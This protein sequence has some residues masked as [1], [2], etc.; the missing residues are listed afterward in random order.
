MI[1]TKCEVCGNKVGKLTIPLDDYP[2][3][4]TYLKRKSNTKFDQ[5]FVFCEN[6][7][8][9]QLENI[10]PQEDLYSHKYKFRTSKSSGAD[11]GSGFVYDYIIKNKL[12]E[13]YKTVIDIGCN[14]GY[15][16][17]RLEPYF[18]NLIGVDP[19]L[20]ENWKDNKI[21]LYADFIEHV[22]L[23]LEDCLVIT[24]QVLEHLEYPKMFIKKLLEKSNNNTRFIFAFPC[25]D[26]LV[27][28]YR[29]DQIFHHHQNYFSKASI[30]E[31]LNILGAKITNTKINPHYWGTLLV[32]FHKHNKP[33]NKFEKI[34]RETVIDSYNEFIHLCNNARDY[35]DNHKDIKIYGYGANLQLPVLGYFI[36][37][38]DERLEYVLDDDIEKDGLYVPTMKIKIKYTPSVNL[39]GK[40]IIIT[41][42]NFSKAILKNIL[43]K[44]IEN[45]YCIFNKI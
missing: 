41:A 22:D 43:E 23:K 33:N 40:Q 26:M 16:L 28:D 12:Y 10:L 35:L 5:R 2:L 7:G 14:D 9:G 31:L 3:T 44:D 24:S 15:L 13:K 37:N 17:Y 11:K 18:D 1:R 36:D 39:K 27:K 8:H 19:V 45:V 6:C 34:G 20:D 32:D 42:S 38:L 25:L 30:G 4:E 21:T 29:F